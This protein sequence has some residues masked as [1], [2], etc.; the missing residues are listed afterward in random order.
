[1]YQRRSTAGS[2][3]VATAGGRV[4]VITSW[5]QSAEGAAAECAEEYDAETDA[6][7]VRRWRSRTTLGGWT[8]WAFEIGEPKAGA[9][10]GGGGGDAIGGGLMVSSRSRNPVFVP[11]DAPRQFVW[12]IRNLPYPKPTYQLSVDEETQQLVLRTT[13][14]KYFKRFDVP[15]LKRLD[16]KL[17]PSRISCRHENATLIVSYEK[18]PPVLQAEAQ[19]RARRAA[20]KQGGGGGEV[21]ECKQQ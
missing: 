15:A 18:P 17:E 19:I 8:R 2:S 13:N 20:K 3:T 21:P 7:L 11:Q 14:K 9:G 10:S 12:R 5:P 1:M 16:L 4:R 6:L